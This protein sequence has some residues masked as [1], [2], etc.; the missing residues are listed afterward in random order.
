MSDPEDKAFVYALLATFVAA[1][2]IGAVALSLLVA[3]AV[4][5]RADKR[6][7]RRSGRVV[8]VSPTFKD[9]ETEWRCAPVPTPSQEHAP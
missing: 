7:C 4:G 8:V 2:L 3:D 9:G 6:E 1:M 5:T